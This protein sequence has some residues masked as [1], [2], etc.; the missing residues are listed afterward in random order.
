MSKAQSQP[1]QS[2]HHQSKGKGNLLLENINLINQRL[3]S[4]ISQGESLEYIDF[5]ED[6]N[7][8][9]RA[10]IQRL[11]EELELERNL[12]YHWSDLPGEMNKNILLTRIQQMKKE[13]GVQGR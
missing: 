9:L 4:E 7:S 2:Q 11:E 12:K 5:L 13:Y 10:K 6:Q 8:T 1:H 3:E